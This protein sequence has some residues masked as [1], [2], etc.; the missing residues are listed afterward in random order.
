MNLNIKVLETN[1]VTMDYVSWLT[2]PEVIK[3]SSNQYKNISFESQINYVQSCLDNPNQDLFG[4]FDQKKHIGNILIKGFLDIHQRAEITYLVGDKFYW[5]KGVGS[6]AV[7]RLIE[8]GKKKYKLKKLIA[9]IAHK[10]IASKKV[11]TKN[12]FEI[13]G[14]RP[15]HL[16]LNGKFYDQIDFGLL[17]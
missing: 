1:D 7:S 17:L 13:E 12:K 3:Y 10:N 2:D 15:D 4:I 14:I 16:Y 6:F 5:G 11:L 9:G 8:F